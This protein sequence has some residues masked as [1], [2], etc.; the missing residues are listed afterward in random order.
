MVA[1]PGGERT[2]DENFDHG[3]GAHGRQR[4][5]QRK[6][7][8]GKHDPAQAAASD[9]KGLTTTRITTAM[10]ISTGNSLNHRYQT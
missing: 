3:F 4:I 1:Q 9:Q 10:R 7:D 2:L 5:Q 8:S 6:Y